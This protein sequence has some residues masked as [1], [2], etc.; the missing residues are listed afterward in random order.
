[1]GNKE[2]IYEL[3]KGREL[4]VKNISEISEFTEN[5]ARVYI[6]R[7]KDKDLVKETGKRGRYITYT[8]K[9][10]ELEAHSLDTQILKKL[11]IPFAKNNISV[12]LQEKEIKRI[13]ILME[14]LKQNA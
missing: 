3:L 8:A 4:S 9:G 7:L 14:E 2:Q 1:M 12:D 6:H 10:S 11:I 13:K 5:E